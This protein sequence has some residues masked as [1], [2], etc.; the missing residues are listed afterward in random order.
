M[1]GNV[2][3][4]E[5]EALVYGVLSEEKTCLLGNWYHRM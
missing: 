4:S 3:I 2:V 1:I 5:V